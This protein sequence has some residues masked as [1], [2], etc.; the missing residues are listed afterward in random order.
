[1]WATNP[2]PAFTPIREEPFF[3]RLRVSASLRVRAKIL[4][5]RYFM[6]GMMNSASP[7]ADSGQ[8]AVTVFS[9]V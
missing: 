1:M 8:R 6:V 7:W 9:L 2:S 3:Y 4:G 5:R